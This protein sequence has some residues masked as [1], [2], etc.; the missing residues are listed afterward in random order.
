MKKSNWTDDE[1]KFLVKHWHKIS[2]KEIAEKLG[3]TEQ[4]VKDKANKIITFEHMSNRKWSEY[5]N[6]L[7][8]KL[9]GTINLDNLSKRLK[10]TKG[11]I[12]KQ[13]F[14]LEGT[15]SALVIQPLYSVD[16]VCEFIGLSRN[17]IIR[18]I[19]AGVIPFFK[20]N[21]QFVIKDDVFW[22]WLKDNL[23]EPNYNN[24]SDE[25]LMFVPEWYSKIISEKKRE[26]RE[27]RKNKPWTSH[28]DALLWSM[29]L[30]GM[31][32]R[33]IAENLNRGRSSISHR[34]SHLSKKKMSKI[35]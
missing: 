21:R 8:R 5:E 31:S 16:D 32:H 34:A 15:K 22:R 23:H 1:L 18:R 3:R 12:L 4:N 29:M 6:E 24:I 13:I 11:A 17:T 25:V 26:L 10:R 28:E 20:V 30:K 9:Y 35:G 14:K 27:D 7:L 33:I 2:N 19:N